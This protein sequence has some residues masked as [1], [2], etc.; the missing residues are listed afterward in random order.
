MAERWQTMRGNGPN[1]QAYS[2]FRIRLP[3][4]IKGTVQSHLV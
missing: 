4:L 2:S 1:W 3:V